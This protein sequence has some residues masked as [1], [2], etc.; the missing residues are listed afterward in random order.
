[1]VRRYRHG[2]HLAIAQIFYD[3]VHRLACRGVPVANAIM[4]CALGSG[5]GSPDGEAEPSTCSTVRA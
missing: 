3:A 1:M 5:P 4:E 2:D